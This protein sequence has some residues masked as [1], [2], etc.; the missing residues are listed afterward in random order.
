MLIE[1]YLNFHVFLKLIKM[2][3]P[4]VSI[5]PKVDFGK[6]QETYG[7]LRSIEQMSSTNFNNNPLY[8]KVLTHK[9]RKAIEHLKKIQ[10]QIENR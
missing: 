4:M 8:K 10:E 5:K 9:L 7:K 6:Y 3:K 2:K 1:K